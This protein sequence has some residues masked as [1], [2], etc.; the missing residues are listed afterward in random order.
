MK[1][2][3]IFYLF[4]LIAVVAA[5]SLTIW[6]HE[7]AERYKKE[8]DSTTAALIESTSQN[9]DGDLIDNA[10]VESESEPVKTETKEIKYTETEIQNAKDYVNNYR[11]I[12]REMNTMILKCVVEGNATQDIDKDDVLKNCNKNAFARFKM[13]NSPESIAKMEEKYQEQLKIANQ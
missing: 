9:E 11:L 1:K 2:K 3:I 5:V 4:C 10:L 8:R 6:F 7:F 12:Q 13:S